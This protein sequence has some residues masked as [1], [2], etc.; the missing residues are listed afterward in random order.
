M[1]ED[2]FCISIKRD[3]SELSERIRLAEMDLGIKKERDLHMIETMESIKTLFKEHNEEEMERYGTISKDLRWITKIVFLGM[4][5]GV[6][7]SFLGVER[8]IS[9]FGG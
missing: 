8:L 6:A 1:G 2:N 9:I 5:V 7:V 3:V 4:G